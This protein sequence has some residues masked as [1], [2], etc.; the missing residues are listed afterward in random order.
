MRLL[1]LITDLEIGGTPTVVR[2]LALRL[3]ASS[4]VDVYVGCLKGFGPVAMELQRAG[5]PVK[6]FTAASVMDLP[7]VVGEL[8]AYVR[9]QQIDT[10]L[11]F[12]IHANTVAAMAS[13]GVTGMRWLQSI[14]TTQ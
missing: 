3:R 5:V 13:R 2:E 7:A 6:S 11:S 14:Q 12:L 4:A 8:R 1:L 10:V 9:D